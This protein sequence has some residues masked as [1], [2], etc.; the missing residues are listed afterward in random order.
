MQISPACET[1]WGLGYRRSVYG[2]FWATTHCVT[3]LNTNSGTSKRPAKEIPILILKVKQQLI[4]SRPISVC[5]SGRALVWKKHHGH[6]VGLMQTP[7]W[8]HQPSL[9]GSLSLKMYLSALLDRNT[10][11]WSMG[12]YT[13][14][15]NRWYFNNITIY[16]CT[17]YHRLLHTTIIFINP[18]PCIRYETFGVCP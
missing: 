17:S 12:V 16:V 8:G 11:V 13:V 6:K 2:I 10:S 18:K 15:D 3:L 14:R 9:W 5:I 7:L 4:G 1:F